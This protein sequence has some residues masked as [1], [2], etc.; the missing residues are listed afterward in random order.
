MTYD[1]DRKRLMLLSACVVLLIVLS[2]AA[3][4]VTGVGLGMPARAELAL[5]KQRQAVKEP[6]Q[7]AVPTHV[8]P[9]SSQ[10]VLLPPKE[11]KAATLAPEPKE[12]K[13]AIA[14][15]APSNP[16]QPPASPTPA[17]PTNAAQPP[18]QVAASETADPFALQVGSFLDA[19]NARQFQ[20]ELKERG[21][22][23]SVVTFLD[24][25]QRE[26]H[27]VRIGGYPTL[28]SATRAAADFSGKE[29]VQALVRRSGAL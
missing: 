26:W 20:S 4:L 5:L 8:N 21:Y 25:N 18:A 19:K 6:A 11:A 12:T 28:T 7:A 3:G 22:S 13:T 15:P 29:R 23:A 24:S 10:P 1:F 16:A 9:P 27:A 14:E 17:T 2:F